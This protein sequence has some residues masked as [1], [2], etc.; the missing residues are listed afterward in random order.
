M[1]REASSMFVQKYP[2]FAQMNF[3]SLGECHVERHTQV[4]KGG[5]HQALIRPGCYL[6]ALNVGDQMGLKVSHDAT[7][8]FKH[9]E[10]QDI[11]DAFFSASLCDL[12][13]DMR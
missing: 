3:V 6:V 2:L 9:L 4:D 7:E 8:L 12:K 13:T 1:E 10:N 5:R 11:T